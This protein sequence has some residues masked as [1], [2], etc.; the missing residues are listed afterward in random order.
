[1]ISELFTVSY[2]EHDKSP[3]RQTH[4]PSDSP[5][6]FYGAMQVRIF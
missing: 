2:I 6:V 1:L 5:A 4:T 3:V